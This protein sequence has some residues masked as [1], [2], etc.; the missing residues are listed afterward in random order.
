MRFRF[1]ASDT[2]PQSL[3]EAAVDAFRVFDARACSAAVACGAADLATPLGT[4]DAGDIDAFIA[5]FLTGSDASD[6]A[7][8]AG[9]M[10][11]SD[12]NAF[13]GAFLAGCP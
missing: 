6:L 10:N 12:I 2:D 13:I 8:P 9:V 1:I 7:A 4:L 3:V 5:G 11:S